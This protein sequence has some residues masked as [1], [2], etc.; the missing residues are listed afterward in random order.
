M[1]TPNNI[2]QRLEYLRGEIKNEC[3]SYAELLDLQSLASYIDPGD[4]ELLE[5]A[6]VEE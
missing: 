2:S 1:N 5:M 6:G 4:S 3:I